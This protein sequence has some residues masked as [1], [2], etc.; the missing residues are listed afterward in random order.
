[1]LSRLICSVVAV[2]FGKPFE[3]LACSVRVFGDEL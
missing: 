2:V 1:M 3:E